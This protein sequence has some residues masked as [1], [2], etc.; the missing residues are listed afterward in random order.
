MLF[1][2]IHFMVSKI[3]EL[4]FSKK[5]NLKKCYLAKSFVTF[6]FFYSFLLSA[7]LSALAI[8]LLNDGKR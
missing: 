1:F 4:F 5:K 3:F 7:Y 2:N 8:Q 6:R